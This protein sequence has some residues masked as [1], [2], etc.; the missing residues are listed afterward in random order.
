MRINE[1]MTADTKTC[2]ESATIADAAKRMRESDIGDV[3]VVDDEGALQ[4]ILT[5]RD[6]VLRVV[7]DERD[8]ESVTVGEV[9]SRDVTTLA[10]E[11]DAEEAARMMRERGVRRL[12]V[13]SDGRPVGMVTLGDLAVERDPDSALADISAQPGNN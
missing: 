9:C 6:I 3:L 7:A 5:D 2:A 4:G 8:P 11:A 1:A 13:V 12:P 10:P